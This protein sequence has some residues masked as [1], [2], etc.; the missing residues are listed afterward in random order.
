[1]IGPVLTAVLAIVAVV[2]LMDWAGEEPRKGADN[3]LLTHPDKVRAVAISPEG[4]W[5]ASGGYQGSVT[6]YDLTRKRIGAVLGG[7]PGALYGLAFSPDG[8]LLAGAHF[9]GTATL[10]ETKSWGLRREFRADTGALL[11]LAFSP[12]GT[13][14]ATAGGDATIGLW[15]RATWCARSGLCGHHRPITCVRFSPDGHTLASCDAGQAVRL[16]D[17]SSGRSGR[18]IRPRFGGII[19][20]SIAWPS[21]PAVESLP[22]PAPRPGSSSGT[23]RAGTSGRRWASARDRS[24]A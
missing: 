14:L 4:R 23:C 24:T 15:D 21:R 3:V 13:L 11:S 7:K 16:W 8:A 22:S 12:D 5:L 18:I 9:D 20:L 6:V 17:V 19:K 10:W 1:M 2:L